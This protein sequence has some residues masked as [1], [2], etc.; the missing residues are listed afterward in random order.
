MMAPENPLFACVHCGRD[1]YPNQLIESRLHG[2]LVCQDCRADQGPNHP[3]RSL[4]MVEP[5]AWDELPGRVQP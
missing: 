1:K 3:E 4:D 5:V 2:G